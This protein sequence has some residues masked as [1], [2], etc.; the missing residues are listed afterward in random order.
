[1]G[2]ES[3]SKNLMGRPGCFWLTYVLTANSLGDGRDWPS[4]DE[5]LSFPILAVDQ[6]ARPVQLAYAG[7]LTETEGAGHSR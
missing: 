1:N 3:H 5:A 6:P 4:I 7:E 2:I